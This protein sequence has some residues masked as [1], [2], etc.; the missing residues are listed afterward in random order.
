MRDLPRYFA[1]PASDR[2]EDWPFWFV[3]DREKGEINVTAELLPPLRGYLPFLPADVAVELA[4]VANEHGADWHND[5]VR[6]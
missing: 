3:A 6:Q 2:T 4:A 5:G 1:R